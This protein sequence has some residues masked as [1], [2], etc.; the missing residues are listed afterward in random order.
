M[1]HSAERAQHD[2]IPHEVLQR[3][4]GNLCIA[5]DKFEWV[6]QEVEFL[7]YAISGEGLRITDEKA[8]QLGISKRSSPRKM[9]SGSAISQ[10]HFP[11]YA[12]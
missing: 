8:R 9:Y 6:V 12:S 11:S 4:K 1:V 5:V 7:R 10:G 2:C 3:H